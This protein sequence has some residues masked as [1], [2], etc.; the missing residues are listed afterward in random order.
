MV[1]SYQLPVDALVGRL[2]FPAILGLDTLNEWSAVINV[3]RGTIQVEAEEGVNSGP[4]EGEL[5]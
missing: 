2:A 4:C 1:G 5:Y 3:G